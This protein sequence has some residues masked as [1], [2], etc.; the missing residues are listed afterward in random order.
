MVDRT[1]NEAL[2]HP[3]G[4]G[5]GDS[6]LTGDHVEPT[7]FADCGEE[8]EAR[9]RDASKEVEDDGTQFVEQRVV[10]SDGSC[11]GPVEV[12][13]VD[14]VAGQAVLNLAVEAYHLGGPRTGA[15]Q[16]REGVVVELAQFAVDPDER[17]FRG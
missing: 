9:R 6:S 7:V 16:H 3:S 14:V 12:D 11:G 15:G 4:G 1:A 2:D 13:L 8:V 5:V 10:V 17:P